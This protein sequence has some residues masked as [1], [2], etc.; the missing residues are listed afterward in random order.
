[1]TAAE[2]AI[3]DRPV[4]DRVSEE[5]ELRAQMYGLLAHFLCRPADRTALNVA[6]ALEGDAT[7]LGQSIAT[8]ARVAGKSSPDAVAQEYQDLFIGVG[9]GELLPYASYYLTGFLNEKPLA[10]LRNEMSELGIERN[11]DVKEPEDHIAALFEMMAGLIRGDFDR[12]AD[13]AEQKRFF[14]AHI[15]SWAKHFFT[16]LQAA[17]SSVLYGALGGVG[18]AFLDIEEVAFTM[19]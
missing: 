11:D 6:A 5:D 16:D 9:H 12:R 7:A 14:D 18:V 13:L 4:A 19:D 1:M 10:K 3:A 2:A 8:F 15:G 17:K